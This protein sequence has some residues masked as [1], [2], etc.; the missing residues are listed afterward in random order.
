M[1]DET[2]AQAAEVTAP[3]GQTDGAGEL[4]EDTFPRAYVEDLRR[5]SAGHRTRAQAAEARLT[6]LTEAA[7]RAARESE[8]RITAAE[9][10]YTETLIASAILAGAARMG[11]IDPQDAVR[12]ADTARVAVEDGRVA[13]ADTALEELA[14]AKPHLLRGTGATDAAATGRPGASA[15]MNEAIRRAAGL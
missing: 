14:K 9:Q 1:S 13:G 4:R 15:G 11:F 2:Q 8:A 7:A 5:E 10:R 12:L 6:E 3:E